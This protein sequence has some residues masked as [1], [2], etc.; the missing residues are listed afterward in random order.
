MIILSLPIEI[1]AQR[2]LSLVYF[3]SS[4]TTVG[5]S[6]PVRLCCSTKYEFIL[7]FPYLYFSSPLVV[8]S[9]ASYPINGGVQCYVPNIDLTNTAAVMSVL[10]IT[11]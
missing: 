8:L 4:T 1:A 10:D 2:P 3:S 11:S 7:S 6:L 9:G 5:I